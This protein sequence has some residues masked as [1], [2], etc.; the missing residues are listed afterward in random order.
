MALASI[1]RSWNDWVICLHHGAGILDEKG[2]LRGIDRGCTVCR[3]FCL[4]GL[5]GVC[6][7]R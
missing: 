4:G 2:E 1:F 6:S 5:F 7:N 3:I